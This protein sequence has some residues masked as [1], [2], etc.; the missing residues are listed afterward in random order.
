MHEHELVRRNHRLF[1]IFMR[2][3]FRDP[4][5]VNA[6]PDKA[7]IILFPDNDPELLEEN[8]KLFRKA[9]DDGRH[10]LAVQ[11]RLVPETH[12]ILM[13]QVKVLSSPDLASLGAAQR[14][15]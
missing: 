15:K 14:T 12:T 1:S 4:A 10:P 9:Q 7:D 11:I 2:Q 6:V 13:P 5:L 8:L 3:A